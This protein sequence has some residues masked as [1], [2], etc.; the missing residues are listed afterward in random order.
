LSFLGFYTAVVGEVRRPT[1]AALWAP[2]FLP[3]STAAAEGF[4]LL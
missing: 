3:D 4:L 1:S 2:L